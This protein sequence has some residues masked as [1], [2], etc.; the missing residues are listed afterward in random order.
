MLFSSRRNASVMTAVETDVLILQKDD[1][2]QILKDFPLVK[3]RLEDMA[4]A[5]KLDTTMK[6]LG[7]WKKANLTGELRSLRKGQ[8]SDEKYLQ[9]VEKLVAA[10][11][12]AKARSARANSSSPSLAKTAALPPEKKG[13]RIA[14]SRIWSTKVSLQ[15]IGPIPAFSDLFRITIALFPVNK[16]GRFQAVL[17][18]RHALE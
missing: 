6:V 15:L 11:W 5:R 2:D 14:I 3:A 9:E 17:Q 12:R 18:Q 4:G 7:L 8:D 16:P 10:R 13:S 1:T